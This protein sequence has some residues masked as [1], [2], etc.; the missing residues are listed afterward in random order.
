MCSDIIDTKAQRNLST[1]TTGTNME[2][3]LE[4]EIL[5]SGVKKIIKVIIKRFLRTIKSLLFIKI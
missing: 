5:A 4:S 1:D 3:E 2:C